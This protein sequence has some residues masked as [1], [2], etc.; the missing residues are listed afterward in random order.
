MTSAPKGIL[1]GYVTQTRDG[2]T[3]DDGGVT[4]ISQGRYGR[5]VRDT[6]DPSK[7]DIDSN[8]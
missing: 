6:V 2:L 4:G 8:E 3:H 5:R 1:A 7:L